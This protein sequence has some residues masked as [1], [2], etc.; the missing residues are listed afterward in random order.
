MTWLFPLDL[1]LLPAD[2]SRTRVWMP[3]STDL[4]EK[5]PKISLNR[6]FYSVIWVTHVTKLRAHM[7]T[8]KCQLSTKLDLENHQ[9]LLGHVT[10]K[11]CPQPLGFLLL[12]RVNS[13]TPWMVRKHARVLCKKKKYMYIHCTLFQ[14]N[15]NR[16]VQQVRIKCKWSLCVKFVRLNVA[17]SL[18]WK[19]IRQEKALGIFSKILEGQVT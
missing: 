2:F 17:F 8:W 12:L 16:S 11:K 7:W 6:Q 19:R 9:G 4:S 13:T 15:L 10:T 3:S 14:T 18:R 1:K 5:G